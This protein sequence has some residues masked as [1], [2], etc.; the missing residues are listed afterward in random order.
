MEGASRTGTVKGR[1][2]DKADR[3]PKTPE[4]VSNP[5]YKRVEKNDGPFARG[6]HRC[7]ASPLH[8][9]CVQRV[10]K[11]PLNLDVQR[12]EVLAGDAVWQLER[13]LRPADIPATP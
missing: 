10:F 7:A 5:E 11:V 4:A 3:F 9:I 2:N 13:I 1:E 8:I 12:E 6:L